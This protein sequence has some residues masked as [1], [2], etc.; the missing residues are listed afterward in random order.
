MTRWMA[1]PDEW[2]P[3]PDGSQVRPLL[4]ASGRGSMAHFRL[5][6]NQVS[7]AVQHRDVAELWY[8]VGGS[9]EMVVGD[10]G[11][12]RLQRDVAVHVPPRTRFQFRAGADGLDVVAVTMPA[13]PDDDEAIE[14]EAHW[15]SSA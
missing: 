15:S 8:V 10:G 2:V 3:A 13:W 5:L 1:L 11:P 4:V 6:A 9:G 12:F 7:R 14:A